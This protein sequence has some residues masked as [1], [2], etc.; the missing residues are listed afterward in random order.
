MT[1]TAG[2][3]QPDSAA[4]R[5][6][7][8]AVSRWSRPWESTEAVGQRLLLGTRTSGN[9]RWDWVVQLLAV[10]GAKEMEFRLNAN[11]RGTVLVVGALFA[12]CAGLTPAHAAGVQAELRSSA[13]LLPSP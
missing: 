10:K 9:R 12:M 8:A 13:A 11:V 1:Q 3:S 6:R 2:L 4:L 7:R 5:R